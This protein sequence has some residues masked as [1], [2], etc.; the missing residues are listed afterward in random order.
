VSAYC[1]LSIYPVR[2]SQFYWLFYSEFFYRPLNFGFF[3]FIYDLV[4]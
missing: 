4:Y 2:L 3:E 1:F